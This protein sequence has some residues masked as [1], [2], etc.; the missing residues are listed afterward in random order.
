MSKEYIN[1]ILNDFPKYVLS[2]KDERI[3][4]KQGKVEWITQMLLRK[5]FRKTKVS[6]NTRKEFL[7]K[8]EMSVKEDKPL[9]FIILFGGYKHFWNESH[10]DVDWAELFN[11]RF[12]SELFAPILEVHNPG[13]IL[14]YGSEDVII[15]LMDNYPTESLD[16]YAQSF[17]QLL[18]IYSESIPK[19][20]KINYVRTGEKYDSESLKKEV[21][22]KIPEKKKEWDKLSKEEVDKMLHRSNRSVM[23]KG[24]EDLTNLSEEEKQE[25]IRES[26]IIEDTFYEVEADYLGDYFTGD[27]HIPLVLSW[28]LSDEN[29]DNWLTLGSTY[30]SSV[31]F[32]IGRGILQKH[33]DKFIPRVVS[34]EQYLNIKDKLK[35]E[36]IDLMPLNNF[37]KLE[38]FEGRLDF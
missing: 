24:E 20:F 7:D 11:L 30:A 29:I 10:P 16:K 1:K 4:E 21:M 5:K 25:R 32:W 2:P 22:A 14:E 12:M 28:G 8:I 36:N 37:N 34:K 19:N 35:K 26:K 9:F 17:N 38:V 13:V 15:G 18:E 3:I 6:E 23:W 33:K 27:N 31:D